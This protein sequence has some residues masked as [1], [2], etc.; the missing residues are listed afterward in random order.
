MIDYLD[1]DV[2][3]L[4]GLII[5]KGEIIEQ[6]D[7]WICTIEFPFVKPKLEGFDRFSDFLT[8]II[9]SV[10]PRLKAL[11][12][13]YI[14]V[15]TFSRK[16]AIKFDFQY[17]NIVVRN[18][19]MILGEKRSYREFVIPNVIKNSDNEEIIKEFIRGF[20]DVS[21]SIRRSNRDRR[22][23]HR[24]YI[25]VSNSNWELPVQLCD[26]I[27]NRLNVPVHEILWGHP[28]L[29]DPKVKGKSPFREHQLRI[30]AHDFIKIGFYINHKHEILKKLAEENKEK[31]KN[32]LSN[33][34][35]PCPGFRKRAKSKRYH[36]LENDKRLPKYLRGKHFDAYWQI[37]ACCGCNLAKNFLLAN[38]DKDKGKSAL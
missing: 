26:V 14:D 38:N 21:A 33:P 10:F 15:I 18:L 28:N 8:S 6:G 27:Q 30:Y 20:A 35:S 16:V 25:D 7:R 2:A 24:V 3:Y 37:C 12:G 9:T 34:S 17:Q 4:I 5:G 13:G 31:I 11:L 1:E 23:F 22:G 32:G 36:P 19:K 29:R